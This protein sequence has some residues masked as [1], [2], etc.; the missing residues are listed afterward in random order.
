MIVGFYLLYAFLTPV[1]FQWN[2]FGIALCLQFLSFLAL[3][4]HNYNKFA[5]DNDHNYWKGDE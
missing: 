4:Q 2:W 5:S 1:N 3:V